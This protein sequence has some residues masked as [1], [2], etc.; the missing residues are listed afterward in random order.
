V[1]NV[2]KYFRR[3]FHVEADFGEAL[4]YVKGLRDEPPTVVERR[5]GD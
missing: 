5:R 4:E 1:R 2:V 3:K